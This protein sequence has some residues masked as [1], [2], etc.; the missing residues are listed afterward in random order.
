[1][2]RRSAA[3]GWFGLVLRNLLR[4][5]GRAIFT[6]LG[7]ALAVAS[8]MALTGLARGIVEGAGT[9]HEERGADLVVTHRGMVDVFAGSLPESL[10]PAIRRLPGVAAVAAELDTSLELG[11]GHTL[12][13][14][15]DVD[16]FNFQ[17][18]PLSRGR[19]PRPGA[20]EIV[21]GDT[22]AEA[23]RLGIGDEVE[24]NFA[25]FHV[26]GI[27]GYEN[28][29]LR[30]MAIMPIADLQALLSRPGQ[31]TLFQVRLRRAGDPEAREAVRRE[32]AALRPGL[33]V[34][35]TS[36]AVRSSRLIQMIES[37]ALAVSIVALAMGCLSVLNTL[38]MGVEERTRDIGILAAIGWPR[39]RILL[40]ILSEGLVLAAIG[41]LAGCALG[42]I[43]HD[44]LVESLVPGAELQRGAKA[45]QALEALAI[46][47]VVGLV[48]ALLPAWHA[49]RLSPAAALRRQ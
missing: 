18:M 22:L 26:V 28:G 23:A 32:I 8:Y 29:L 38:A 21:I 44:L 25:R 39:K 41:G 46:A 9:S 6:L 47:F 36:E 13:G 17:E 12:V 3:M 48:G 11:D 33:G 31:A 42:W 7:I 49:S 45:I 27:S 14:G 16:G 40:L 19:R 35:T 15:W 10:G 2:R 20:A 34:S 43:G 37:S 24:L 1:M 5:P 30:G 4:R